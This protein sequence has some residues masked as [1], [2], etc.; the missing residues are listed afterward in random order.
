MYLHIYIYIIYI[1]IN[2][3]NVSCLSCSFVLW[4]RET[5]LRG[6]C[7]SRQIPIICPSCGACFAPWLVPCRSAEAANEH[8][9]PRSQG[10]KMVRCEKD[11]RHQ[12]VEF[13]VYKCFWIFT[14]V[15]AYLLDSMH[16]AQNQGFGPFGHVLA[17]CK[18][19][20]LRSIKYKETTLRTYELCRSRTDTYLFWY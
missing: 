1:Y 4:H 3:N 12:K 17:A 14:H 13:D 9:F 6:K 5:I 15:Y 16:A 19:V 7:L 20:Q 10:D 18:Y 2:T 11:M 8:P